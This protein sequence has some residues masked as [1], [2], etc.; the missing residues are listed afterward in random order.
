[1]VILKCNFVDFRYK[2]LTSIKRAVCWSKHDAFSV[3]SLLVLRIVFFEMSKLKRETKITLTDPCRKLNY[4][5]MS[6]WKM[7]HVFLQTSLLPEN[8]NE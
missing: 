4:L 3:S 5:R 8:S 6:N 7:K 2:T 1:M